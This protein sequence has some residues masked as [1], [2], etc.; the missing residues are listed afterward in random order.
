MKSKLAIASF[1]LLSLIFILIITNITSINAKDSNY[2]KEENIVWEE[3]LINHNVTSSAFSS[4]GIP[5]LISGTNLNPTTESNSPQEIGYAFFEENKEL[6]KMNNPRDELQIKSIDVTAK[7]LT[8]TA[9]NMTTIKY[10]QNY[11]EI[12]VRGAILIVHTEDNQILSI[13]GEYIP[14][15]QILTDP[16]ISSSKAKKI[17]KEDSLFSKFRIIR[18]HFLF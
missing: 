13:T 18:N 12:L 3:F 8:P 1:I 16:T 6:F 9:R 10:Q 11:N 5:R 2:S 4:Y 15:L 7:L 17:A 14:N